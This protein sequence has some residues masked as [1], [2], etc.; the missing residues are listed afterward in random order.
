[1]FSVTMRQAGPRGLLGHILVELRV[2]DCAASAS[3][4]MSHSIFSTPIAL[5][6]RSRYNEDGNK[7]RLI[8]ALADRPRRRYHYSPLM[9]AGCLPPKE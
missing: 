2:P 8:P 9:W 5:D 6:A 7:G 3:S 4:T 1:M